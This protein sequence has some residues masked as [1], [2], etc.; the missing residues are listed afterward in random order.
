[1]SRDIA[2]RWER[3][4]QLKRDGKLDEA[5]KLLEQEARTQEAESAREG[6]GVAPAAFRELQK[7]YRRLGRH[8]DEVAIMRRWR[9]GARHP[10]ARIDTLLEEA[11]RRME[12]AVAEPLPT[13]CPHCGVVL[14]PPPKASRLCPHCREKLVVRT[15][16]VTK[17]KLVLT[18]AGADDFDRKKKAAGVKKKI[19]GRLGGLGFGEADYERGRTEL[20]DQFSGVEPGP[21]DVFWRLANELVMSQE[22]TQ[23]WLDAA[24]TR[25]EMAQHLHDEGRNPT[26]VLRQRF[27]NELRWHAEVTAPGSTS[28]AL[29]FLDISA[30]LNCEPCSRDDGRRLGVAEAQQTMPLP[31]ADCADVYCRCA[32]RTVYDPSA[33]DS[34]GNL[35]VARVVVNVEV[36]YPTPKRK[37]LFRRLLGD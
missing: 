31:H 14:D 25:G 18:P 7:L 11:T 17:E 2:A 27:E 4:K 29:P 34:D 1:V 30:H 26:T 9:V 12:A 32:Y 24:R 36:D 21:G 13:A 10:D 28:T 35:T 19:I 3:I 22:A 8:H 37:R 23:Q 33:Y 16:P 6:G 15:D 5:I 20:R